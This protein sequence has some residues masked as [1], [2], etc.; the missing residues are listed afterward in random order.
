MSYFIRWITHALALIAAAAVAAAPAQT[1]HACAAVGEWT[2]PGGG[3]IAAQEVLARAAR[4]SVVLLGES[5]DN[6]DHHRWQLNTIAGLAALHPRLVLGFE[7]FPRRVQNVLDRWV[8][9]ELDEAAFLK[10]S[11]WSSVWR[12]EAVL[13]LPLFHFARLNRVPMVALNVERE[14]VSEVGATGLEAVP[15]VRREGV[16]DPVPASEAYVNELFAAYAEHPEKG[17]TAARSDPAFGLFVQAQLVWDRAMAQALAEAAGRGALVIG[18]MG[19]GHIAGGHGV[20][21]QLQSLGTTR[22]ASLLPWG[23]DSDCEKFSAGLATAVFGV[24]AARPAPPR[25]LLGITIGKASD[26]IGVIAVRPG[27]IAETAGL[28]AGDVLIEVAGSA[29]KAPGDV[30]PIVESMVPG[31]WLPLKI[32]RRSEIMELTA[33]FPPAAK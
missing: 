17:R 25:P 9:G 1:Q 13:Y 16:T 15:Q 30:R 2:V 23:P 5:H 3:R 7:M 22:I 10:A 31:T 27:S 29:V 33:K 24:P 26:G 21:H 28:R 12:Y 18:I 32:R 8:A 6:A 19:S 11:E 4:E 20:P 14:F